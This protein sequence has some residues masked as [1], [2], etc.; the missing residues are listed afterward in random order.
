MCGAC[1][2]AQSCASGKELFTVAWRIRREKALPDLK[3]NCFLWIVPDRAQK[4]PAKRGR[5]RVGL[6]CVVS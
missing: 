2:Q 3:S 4:S 1:G 5:D 6:R